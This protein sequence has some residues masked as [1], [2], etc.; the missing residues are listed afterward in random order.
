MFIYVGVESGFSF[1]LNSFVSQE[2]NGPN[3]YLAVSL[4]WLAMI[5]SRVL[6]GYFARYKG[7]ILIVATVGVSLFTWLMSNTSNFMV[8]VV[9]SFILG[10]FSGAV[11][12]SVLN[13][14]AEFASKRTATAMGMITAATG[15]GGAIIAVAFGWIT[16][17]YGIRTALIMLGAIMLFDGAAALWLAH[18]ARHHRI[19]DTK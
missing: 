2:L 12:P 15:L 1:F 14:A 4:F 9:L 18:K 5:P 16:S 3:A 11:Y 19:Y 8:A 17:A 10:F 6:C 13:F 7:R